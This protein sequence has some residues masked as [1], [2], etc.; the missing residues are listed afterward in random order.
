[1]IQQGTPPA[2]TMNDA[3]DLIKKVFECPW[4]IYTR[5][6][7]CIREVDLTYYGIPT[8]NDLHADEEMYDQWTKTTRTIAELAEF[9]DQGKEFMFE[10][11]KSTEA[12]FNIITEY[13][14]YV[15]YRLN[16][17]VDLNYN[18]I[19][20]NESVKEV[21]N[22]VVKLQNLGNHI[23]PIMRTYIP[24]QVETQGLLG[25]LNERGMR[26]GLSQ[27]DFNPYK[28]FGFNGNQ[29]EQNT[30]S[31]N[32]PQTEEAIRIQRA[33]DMSTLSRLRA[34]I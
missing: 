32:E 2:S 13:T 22:D 23:C 29:T 9:Y 18:K 20:E 25:F 8:S 27:F 30:K 1:M 7:W 21:L 16:Y 31:N 4:I 26:Y 11:I 6:K 19:E 34:M 33:L 3:S 10:D 17:D 15:A 24:Q 5:V 28:R 14:D 12:V